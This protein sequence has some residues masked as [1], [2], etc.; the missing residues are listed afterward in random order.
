MKYAILFWLLAAANVALAV[1]QL[2]V[3]WQQIV[4]ATPAFTFLLVGLVYALQKP[5]WFGKSNQGH[6]SIVGWCVYGLFF[7]LSHFTLW[8]YRR[9]NNSQPPLAEVIPGLWIG[10]RLTTRE[11]RSLPLRFA[12]ILDLAAE[13]PRIPLA[14]ESYCSLPLLDGLPVSAQDLA[15]ARAWL[16]ENCPRGPTLV[17]CALGHG[18]TG[19]IVLAYLLLEEQFADATEGLKRLRK[20]RPGFGMSHAQI[21][22]VERFVSDS[23][24]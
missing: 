3:L 1:T 14:A 6:Q 12:G 5:A 21:A 22:A 18:R 13:F 17:H 19:S 11:A 8:C 4:A 23:R 2:D 10:R 15:L 9:A 7:L 16:A 24:Q 20:L